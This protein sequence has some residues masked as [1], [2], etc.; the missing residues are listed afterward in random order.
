MTN[1]TKAAITYVFG[2]ISGIIFLILN[3]E[4][5]FVR[6]S[7]AQST[8][9]SLIYL[10]LIVLFNL[11]PTV[12][13]IIASIITVFAFIAWVMLIIKATH[14]IYLKIPFVSIISEKY[15]LNQLTKN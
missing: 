10:I 14:N 3:K 13:T 11:I 4:S 9:F 2:F 12:G 7:A 8:V 6:K 1:Q 5:E 15:V